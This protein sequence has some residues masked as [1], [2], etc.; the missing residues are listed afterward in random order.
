MDGLTLYRC[1]SSGKRGKLFPNMHI[2]VPSRIMYINGF[3]GARHLIDNNIDLDEYQ[4]NSQLAG[5]AL[6]SA[7]T[8]PDLYVLFWLSNVLQGMHTRS[9]YDS[10]KQPLR[11]L[12]RGA[13]EQR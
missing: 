13:Y 6:V 10:L 7:N 11:S 4:G 8:S 12:Q 3:K 9:H 2:Q 5:M 1:I